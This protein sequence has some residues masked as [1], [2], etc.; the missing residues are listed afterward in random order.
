MLSSLFTV[1]RA[2]E[3][4]DTSFACETRLRPLFRRFNCFEAINLLSP[5]LSDSHVSESPNSGRGRRLNGHGK[6]MMSVLDFQ[7]DS[8]KSREER[9]LICIANHNKETR[10]GVN[11]VKQD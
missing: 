5:G 4:R 6:R 7:F 8:I 10:V 2:A 11:R 9:D 1:K 3:R